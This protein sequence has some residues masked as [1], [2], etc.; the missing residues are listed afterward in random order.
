MKKL[1]IFIAFAIIF[2][3]CGA[4][5]TKDM[6]ADLAGLKGLLKNKQTEMLNLKEEIDSIK[7]K[8]EKL[9]PNFM[10]KEIP[11]VEL[12]ELKREDFNH[13]V[14]VQGSIDAGETKYVS[15]EL[16]GKIMKLYVKEG[17]RIKRGQLLATIDA[18]NIR[19]S[20]EEL[21][22]GLE[23]AKDLYDRQKRLWEKNI[24]SEIQYL[25]A[26]NNM[27]RLEKSLATANTSLAKSRI[28][29]PLSGTV[30]RLMNKEGEVASPGMPI[31]HLISISKV[32][33]KAD[34]P[35][36]YIRDIK[37]KD[38]VK[39]RVPVLDLEKNVPVYRIGQI[40][41]QNNRT[42]EV[43]VR[44]NNPNYELKPNL[45]AMLYVNDYKV[46]D[47]VAVPLEL[48]QQDLSGKSFVFA[49]EEKEG[50]YF[51]A[52]KLIETGIVYEG[53]IE[54]LSGLEGTEKLVTTGAQYLAEGEEVMIEEV[55][56]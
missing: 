32:K 9:D 30:A 20:I 12:V 10:K 22:T 40:I 45:L 31:L 4:T 51:V 16:P 44:L 13:Y 3:A 2:A 36:V 47:A 5:S 35:E 34:V 41:N 17:N 49:V 55:N 21:N 46:E 29:S 28:Y 33:I 8:I 25:Q 38:L 19:K 54:V 56:S 26:K 39:V 48:V 6:P 53:K 11:V 42:F 43:E 18:E 14:E 23:L 1:M 27:E 15:S 50:K 37:R 7:V 52:K 24:G